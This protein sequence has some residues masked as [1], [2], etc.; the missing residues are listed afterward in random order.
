MHISSP[1]VVQVQ[2]SAGPDRVTRYNPYSS[3]IQIG[4]GRKW[5]SGGTGVDS[6]FA[7]L[8][9]RHRAAAGLTQEELS[10]GS[11]VSVQAISTLERGTRRYPQLS[12]V[13][14]LAEALHLD[15]DQAA[16]LAAAA[17]RRGKADKPAPKPSLAA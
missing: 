13:D 17:S 4:V 10:E 8:L 5:R 7:A 16:A 12:T 6:Q 2:F 3:P 9:R 15:A 11:G 14:A 1:V